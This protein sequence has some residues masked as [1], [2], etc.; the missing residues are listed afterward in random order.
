M[1]DFKNSDYIEKMVSPLC[2]ICKTQMALDIQEQLQAYRCFY[3]SMSRC[4][5]VEFRVRLP[6]GPS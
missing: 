4:E 6:K 3:E 5:R 1:F 2:C